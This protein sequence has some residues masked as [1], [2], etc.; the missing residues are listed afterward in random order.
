VR[1]AIATGEPYKPRVWFDMSGNK[2]AMLGNAKSWYDVF[3]EVDFIIG[4]Y[5]MLTS[6]HI[7]AADLVFPVR[8]WLEEPMVNMN[9]LGVTFL[10]NECT[11]IGETVSHTIPGAQVVAAC[12][13]KWGGHIPNGLELGDGTAYMGEA[14]E[15]EVKQSVAESLLAPDWDTLVNNIDDYVP[16]RPD[17]YWQY[18][19]HEVVVDDGLPAGF[20]TESRKIE[21]Y[22]QI[23]LK[24]ARTGYPFCYPEPQEACEDYSPIC[25]FIEPAESPINDALNGEEGE[26]P[27]ILTSGRV[28][29]FHHGTM[30]HAA[31]SR[32]LYPA[33][34]VRINPRSAAELGIEHR[35]WVKVT[36]RRGEISGRAYLTEGVA[37]GVVWME[38]FWNPECYDESVPAENRTAGWR[39]CNVNV[40]TKNSA[41]FNEVYGSYTNRGFTVRVEKGEKPANIWVEP[42]E[43]QP[44]MPTLQSEP[45][46]KDV[47]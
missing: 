33:P 41:P 43:F 12:R 40:L 28:P 20:A 27:F 30:R 7:E 21:V 32:E 25:E 11:H 9:Q 36:S 23:L 39:E 47:F 6:F 1:E 26:Y 18:Y 19:Q 17:G 22:C 14:T 2:L 35:D 34:D 15:A 10:Q 13:E 24:L 29:Y 42:K 45:I 5:P 44:F 46:T 37:P 4:Q 38:R 31:F 8:E 3:P 16:C